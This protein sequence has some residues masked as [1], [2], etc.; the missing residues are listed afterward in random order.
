M[1]FCKCRHQFLKLTFSLKG[2]L[3]NPNSDLV[4]VS[5][6]HLNQLKCRTGVNVGANISEKERFKN[7]QFD[8]SFV[9]SPTNNTLFCL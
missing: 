3:D 6:N 2:N 4:H 9:V 5:N 1:C 7:D 8:G